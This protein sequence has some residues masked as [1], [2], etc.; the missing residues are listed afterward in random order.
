[1]ILNHFLTLFVSSWNKF[2]QKKYLKEFTESG[3]S[4]VQVNALS[5]QEL[6]GFFIKPAQHSPHPKIQA[7]FKL[8]PG[9]DALYNH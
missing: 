6:E 4:F 9:L 7:L 3:L 8:L 5:D 2:T 1:M